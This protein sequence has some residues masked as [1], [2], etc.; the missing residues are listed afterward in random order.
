MSCL[1]VNILYQYAAMKDPI[2][3]YK[4]E[5][6]ANTKQI[7]DDYWKIENGKFLN[8]VK[9]LLVKYGF[10]LGALEIVIKSNSG[11][12]SFFPEC[13]DC[14][15]ETSKIVHLR[16]NIPS[17]SY[18]GFRCTICSNNFDIVTSR[19]LILRKQEQFQVDMK[20]LEIGISEKKWLDLYPTEL[21]ILQKIVKYKTKGQIIKFAFNK[22]FYDRS[23][24][25][26][27]SKLSKLN[28]VVVERA[29]NQ[30]IID[31]HFDERLEGLIKPKNPV[32]SST[33]D[34]LSLSLCKKSNITKPEDPEYSGTFIL[35]DNIIFKKN[36]LYIYA[37]WR[38]SDGSITFKF[39]P[40]NKINK[41]PIQGIIDDNPQAIGDIL[42]MNNN[43]DKNDVDSSDKK[44]DSDDD[45]CN[46]QDYFNFG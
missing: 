37:G 4:P 31:F 22:D 34:I 9:N 38:N 30:S 12:E 10:K 29:G 8:T 3:N 44:D 45:N 26:V 40:A 35:P 21:E 25:K 23:I 46:D 20:N 43:F 15:V 7:I 42:K 6:D 2:I 18:I 17:F 13:I 36:E 11:Y 33:N 41:K 27:V 14:K 28:L 24:W 19:N 39:T 1:L 5:I 16:R 32:T